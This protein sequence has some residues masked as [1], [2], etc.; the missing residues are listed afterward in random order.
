MNINLVKFVGYRYHLY[1]HFTLV[2][3][4]VA[5]FKPKHQISEVSIVMLE[6]AHLEDDNNRV[7]GAK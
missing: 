6:P 5:V 4:H 2:T 7:N 3:D 1:H